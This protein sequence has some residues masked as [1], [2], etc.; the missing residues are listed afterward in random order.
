[1]AVCMFSD[2]LPPLPHLSITVVSHLNIAYFVAHKLLSQCLPLLSIK[3]QSFEEEVSNF[4]FRL[5]KQQLCLLHVLG[6]VMLQTGFMLIC[7]L[8]LLQS[9][10]QYCFKWPAYI[11]I[12]PV[13]YSIATWLYW[14]LHS[15]VTLL[16]MIIQQTTIRRMRGIHKTIHKYNASAS[17]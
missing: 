17:K 11:W 13:I 2:P 4:P 7:V 6:Y 3:P 5:K 10:F 1:M 15:H 8:L 12:L 14:V 16:G 9:N